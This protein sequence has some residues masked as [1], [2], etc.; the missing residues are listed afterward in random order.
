MPASGGLPTGANLPLVDSS[1]APISAEL[2]DW[3]VDA[4]EER[5][6]EELE[7]RGMRFQPGVF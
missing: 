5:I 2:L 3:I 4:V 7:R 1:S 6:L